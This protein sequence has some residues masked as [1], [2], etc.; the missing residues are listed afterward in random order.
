MDRLVAGDRAPSS[1]EGAEMLTRVDPTLDRPMILFQYIV[2]ILHRS[3]STV[4]LQSALG[5]ELYDGWRVSGVLESIENNPLHRLQG[6]I[7]NGRPDGYGRHPFFPPRRL[8][9][10]T[11]EASKNNGDGHG[12]SIG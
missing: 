2:E 7:M 6:A 4:L 10:R 5:F 9:L 3:M 12:G 11:R 1:P 8:L